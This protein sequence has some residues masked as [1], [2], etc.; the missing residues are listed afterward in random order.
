MGTYLSTYISHN[1]NKEE[2]FKSLNS[3]NTNKSIIR[4]TGQLESLI[5]KEGRKT[6]NQYK[7]YTNF[8]FK[9]SNEN[10]SNF[11]EFKKLQNEGPEEPCI[12]TNNSFIDIG[13]NAIQLNYHLKF[14]YFVE[15]KIFHNTCN[16]L[17]LALG[18]VLSS[19]LILYYADEG[20]TQIIPEWIFSNKLNSK[21]ILEKLSTSQFLKAS[22][23]SDLQIVYNNQ[24]SKKNRGE[25]GY[26]EL[27]NKAYA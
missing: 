3:I 11:N 5:V 8:S 7:N 6:T 23:I 21:Q 26:F 15:N 18:E 22:Q 20:E 13:Q 27:K 19:N 1:L 4:L 25:N 2:L 10:F 14:S 9:W 24:D 17:N 16:E 12:H